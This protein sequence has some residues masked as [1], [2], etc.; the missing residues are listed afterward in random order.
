MHFPLYAFAPIIRIAQSPCGIVFRMDDIALRSCGTGSLARSGR[1][2][3]LAAA[4]RVRDPVP[5]RLL[6][7]ETERG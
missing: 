4:D 2:S 6:I 3:G 5:H 1:A 7:R